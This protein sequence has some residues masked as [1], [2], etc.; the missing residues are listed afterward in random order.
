ML[1][2]AK[3]KSVTFF[4]PP[5]PGPP[6]TAI[7]AAKVTYHSLLCPSSVMHLSGMQRENVGGLD[8]LFLKHLSLV[9]DQTVVILGETPDHSAD[10]E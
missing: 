2:Y 4:L 5:G 9:E 10:K 7:A 8:A 6:A 3:G 1:H